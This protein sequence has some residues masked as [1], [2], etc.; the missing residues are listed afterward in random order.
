M[1]KLT[2]LQ[3]KNAKSSEKEQLLAGGEGLNLKISPAGTK[4]WIYRYRLV[5]KAIR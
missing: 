4:S 5:I 3:V 1:G 2:I